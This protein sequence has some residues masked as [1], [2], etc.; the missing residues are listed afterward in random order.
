MRLL[1]R[2]LKQELFRNPRLIGFFCLHIALGLGGLA[3]LQQ[4]RTGISNELQQQ[5][6]EMLGADI[7]VSARAPVSEEQLRAIE[8]VLP[9]GYQRAHIQ[10]MMTMARG[11]AASRLVNLVVR[12]PSYPF[13]GNVETAPDKKSLGETEVWIYPELEGQLGVANGGNLEIG[14]S[15]YS[16][17][18]TITKD[19]NQGGFFSAMAPRIY[20]SP[21]GYEKAGLA[22]Y[23]STARY[24]YYYAL[25]I[26]GSLLDEEALRNIATAITTALGDPS[27]RVRTPG[28]KSQASGRALGYLGD[29]LGL[30]S[31]VALFLSN[32]GMGYLY[33]TYLQER[34]KDMAIYLCIGLKSKDLGRLYFSHL[35]SLG[36]IGTLLSLVVVALVYPLAVVALKDVL[37]IALSS[38]MDV[39]VLLETALVGIG[40]VMCI[41]LP[42]LSSLSQRSARELF[43]QV[44]DLHAPKGLKRLAPLLSGIPYL[45]FLW[46]LA[47]WMSSS[48]RTGSIF[49]LSLGAV[50]VVVL[51]LGRI[52]LSR[53]DHINPKRL[54]LYLAWK[55]ICRFKLSSTAIAAS[56]ALATVL[57]TYIPHLQSTL[58]R[59]FDG[60]PNVPPPSLFLFDIQEDELNDLNAF[61][62]EQNITLRGTSP[63]IRARLTSIND[64]PFSV[65]RADEGSTREEQ[66]S[67]EMRNRGLNLTF[68]SELDPSETILEGE[69]FEGPAIPDGVAEISIERRYA[70]R[71][72]IEMGDRLV[73]D[74]LGIPVEGIITS[75]RGV[76]WTSFMPNFF[77]TL[78]PGAI[79]DAPKTYLAAVPMLE[80]A[81]L[82]S[83]QQKLYKNFP[84]I[85]AVD[86]TRIVSQVR[87]LL[88]QASLALQ[89]MAGLCLLVGFVVLYTLCRSQVHQRRADMRLLFLM[90]LNR[91]AITAAIRWEFTLLSTVAVIFGCLS[92]I[93]LTAIASAAFFDSDPVY[94]YPVMLTCLGAIPALALLVSSAGNAD[95]GAKDH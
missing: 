68:R 14:Q 93:A 50:C 39:S 75:V 27:I 51:L 86:I 94:N 49:I 71:L 33:R 63:L 89:I 53:V 34:R 66:R 30:V 2:L 28:E 74:I 17:S 24:R 22:G 26:N 37:P 65:E 73:I 3:L 79:D 58:S 1:S 18:A 40:S 54:T 46:G 13:Y 61:F 11:E 87:G 84:T 52:I 48:P 57:L 36:I 85:S 70:D 95:L 45:A 88:T 16:L 59:E 31:L 67:F 76:R 44:E 7:S 92:G 38:T 90:G 4:L 19:T 43:H 21:E 60:D 35:M 12:D 6:R 20:I 23:G 81:K 42:F 91:K 64:K 62:A 29:F 83:L 78:Q 80:E 47:I 72:G 5:S 9:P 25:S 32:V 56:L 10:S 55:N 77:I 8:S 82:R 15:T 69:W 41:A